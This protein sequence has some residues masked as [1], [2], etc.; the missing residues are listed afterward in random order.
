MLV[1]IISHLVENSMI[2]GFEAAQA[3]TIS[4]DICQQENQLLLQYQDNGKGM[5][6]EQCEKIF[7]PFF[8]TKYAQG[9]IGLGMHIV[10][11][12]ITQTLGGTIEC[13]SEPGHGVIFYITL[14]IPNT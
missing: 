11:N 5:T 4:L 6:P 3:G 10:Y 7:E 12:L 14:P 2:H 1:Q 9:G 13:H 8:T